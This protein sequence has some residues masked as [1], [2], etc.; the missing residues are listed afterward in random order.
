VEVDDPWTAEEIIEDFGPELLK[1]G[2]P[3]WTI[4][5]NALASASFMK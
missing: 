5:A 4:Q 2:A 3:I 1:L